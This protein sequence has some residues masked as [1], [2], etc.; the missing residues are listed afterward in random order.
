MVLHLPI[1][2]S[3]VVLLLPFGITCV[4]GQGLPTIPIF[5][6]QTEQA[7]RAPQPPIPM[8]PPAGN[9]TSRQPSQPA[10]GD[11]RPPWEAEFSNLP[12]VQR[13]QYAEKLQQAKAAYQEG[14]SPLCL[15]ALGACELIFDKNPH[16]INLKISCL[17]DLNKLNEIP[18]LIK[19]S[20]ALLAENE[21][22]DF[23]ESSLLL[24]QG[25][26]DDCIAVSQRMLE[27]PSYQLSPLVRDILRYRMLLSH[28][29]MGR[30]T[31]A[32]ALVS[33]LTPI[34]DTPLYYMSE[35]AF[36]ICEGDAAQANLHMRAAA[37]IFA[38]SG[39]LVGFVRAF[40]QSQLAEKK[41][42]TPTPSSAQ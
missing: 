20:R 3:S 36:S 30:T 22:A 40:N 42:N 16:A 37:S 9:Q 11:V 4:Q 35:V 13:K 14:N 18:A 6:D 23:S 24:A 12:H 8:T 21:V 19:R 1:L 33:G 10:W 26:Y 15:L 32:K 38:S 29:A 27:A 25:K 39:Q 5:D 7:P 2:L 34:S 28:L 41:H 31:Q 17:L